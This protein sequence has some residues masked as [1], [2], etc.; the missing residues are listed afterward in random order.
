MLHTN[1][2]SPTHPGESS[3]CALDDCSGSVN[4]ELGFNQISRSARSGAGVTKPHTLPAVPRQKYEANRTQHGL[5]QEEKST[6]TYKVGPKSTGGL[7]RPSEPVNPRM[8]T[9]MACARVAHAGPAQPTIMPSCMARQR[10]PIRWPR[11]YEQQKNI[12]ATRQSHAATATMPRA[13]SA[14][15][16]PP[17]LS[18]GA[19][20]GACAKFGLEGAEPHACRSR[21]YGTCRAPAA[22]PTRADGGPG[23]SAGRRAHSAAPTRAAAQPRRAR[24]PRGPAA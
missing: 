16:T 9:A 23:A 15:T 3:L 1:G 22:N 14:G 6:Y 4:E 19:G 11:S 12:L 24:G 7:W 2:L 10:A 5:E 18:A 8:R 17:P 21:G 20:A 13:A